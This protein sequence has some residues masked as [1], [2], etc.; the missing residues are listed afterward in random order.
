[1]Y[2]GFSSVGEFFDDDDVPFLRKIQ[3]NQ[4]HCINVTMSNTWNQAGMFVDMAT[5]PL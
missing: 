2:F 4:T 5:S 3:E 1:M